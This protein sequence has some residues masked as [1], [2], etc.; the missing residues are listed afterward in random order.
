MFSNYDIRSSANAL[1]TLVE[2]SGV[3]I[4][5][6]KKYVGRENEYKYKYSNDF[7]FFEIINSFKS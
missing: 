4:S 3:D 6:W 7:V 5:T 2:L 1:K